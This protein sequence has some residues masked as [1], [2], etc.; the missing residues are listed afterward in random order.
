MRLVPGTVP[1][2][3]D[4]ADALRA[5]LAASAAARPDAVYYAPTALYRS[6]DWIFL[7]VV[8][9]KRVDDGLGWR[10]LEDGAWFGLVLLRQG[11]SG[12]W[13][14]AVEGTADFSALLPPPPKT[15]C[16]PVPGVTSIRCRFVRRARPQPIASRGLPVP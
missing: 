10:L 5:A 6:G 3:S 11:T 1:L 2:D 12:A 15:R 8:G 14:G 16:P 9:L 7:S 4:V 13:T